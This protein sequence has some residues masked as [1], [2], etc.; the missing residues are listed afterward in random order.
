MK[1]SFLG[2]G[3]PKAPV[4]GD[5][6]TGLLDQANDDLVFNPDMDLEFNPDNLDVS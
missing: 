4:P 2:G 3:K 5:D 1:Y 6:L